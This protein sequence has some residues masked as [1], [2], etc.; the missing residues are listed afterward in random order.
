MCI[1]NAISH[2]ANTLRRIS[3]CLSEQV[4]LDA[5]GVCMQSLL[6]LIS[7][8]AVLYTAAAGAS[9]GRGHGAQNHTTTKNIERHTYIVSPF[10]L[11]LRS[12]RTH[13]ALPRGHRSLHRDKPTSVGACSARESN[14]PQKKRLAANDN[15]TVNRYC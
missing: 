12:R 1:L 10:L 8:T 4:L 3:A 13:S 5:C 14:I 11:F 2:L 15:T 6:L 7:A 9:Y